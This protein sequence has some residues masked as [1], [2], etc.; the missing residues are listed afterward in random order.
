MRGAKE[1]R[2]RGTF[3]ELSQ[4]PI[5][6][7][8]ENQDMCRGEGRKSRRVPLG[9]QPSNPVVLLAILQILSRYAT[10]ERVSCRNNLYEGYM[11]ISQNKT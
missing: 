9:P 3:E 7:L 4:H 1:L 10:D 8:L 2:M 11:R 6:G 5:C